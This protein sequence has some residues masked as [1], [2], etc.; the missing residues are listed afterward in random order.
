MAAPSGTVTFLFTDIEG[1]TRLYQEDEHVMAAAVARHNEVLEAIIAEH[2]GTVFS[3]M[4]D[5][6]AA[7]FGSA[8]AAVGAAVDLQRRLDVER[9]PTSR[10]I[11]V[12]VGLHTGEARLLGGDYFGAAVNRAARLMAIGHGGQVLCSEATA[13]VLTGVELVDLGEH[14]LRDLDRAVHVFQ[15]GDG[16]FP[17]LR[18]LEAHPSNL[19]AEV[20]GFVGRQDE[21][22]EVEA[23]LTAARVVTL[24]GAGGVGKTR[25]ALRAAAEALAGFRDGVRLVELSPLAD[26]TRLVE[27]VAGGLGVTERAGQALA[28]AVTEYLRSRHLLL[29]LDNCEHLG[30]ATGRW[31]A[32][33]VGSCP[34][35]WVLATSRR[36]LGVRGERVV[37]VAPLAVPAMGATP[38]EIGATD[39]ARLF[40]DRAADAKSSFTLTKANAGAVAELVRLLDGIP[41][42]IELAAARIRSFTPAELI[43]LFAQTGTSGGFEP[44]RR[45]MDWSY[46]LLDGQAM[47]ALNR[48]SVF[49]GDFDLAAARAVLGAGPIE[50]REVA[51]LLNSLV[52][53]SL[54]AAE[55]DGDATRYRLL[56]T[57][58]QYATEHLDAAGEGDGSRRRHAEH[59]A[60]FAAQARDGSRTSAERQWLAR[61]AR[62]AANLRSAVTWATS[63]GDT[64]L[65]LRLVTPLVGLTGSPLLWA[66][67]EWVPAVIAMPGAAAHPLYPL[68]LASASWARLVTGDTS[69]ALEMCHEALSAA[70]ETDP[71]PEVMAD[72]L[73]VVAQSFQLAGD[74]DRALEVCQRS[75]EL[76][77]AAGDD[78]HL[79]L[80]LTRA[81]GAAPWIDAEMASDLAKE[82]LT[83]GR[84]LGGSMHCYAALS[85]GIVEVERD[86][87]RALAL[88]GESAA[89]AEEAGDDYAY[90]LPLGFQAWLLVHRGDFGQ[91]AALIARCLEAESRGRS[92]FGVHLLLGVAAIVLELAGDDE[93]SAIAHGPAANMGLPPTKGFDLGQLERSAVTVRGRLSDQHFDRW[94][95]RGLAMNDHDLVQYLVDHLRAVEPTVQDG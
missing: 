26:P 9:W 54:I 38:E 19:P 68:A 80:A 65:A 35:L 82:A 17:A 41:L 40:V 23:S 91:A 10:P 83:V 20:G 50:P 56:E 92:S 14:R 21:L 36:R 77:R 93:A 4:G 75:I 29:V 70:A 55:D 63:V 18:S 45:A 85:A 74:A 89:V 84:R 15:V 32:N 33:A 24:T 46:A 11:R 44:L 73:S 72:V 8:S 13:S 42:A 60:T 66:S 5:G 76:A 81:C 43:E 69:T 52:D 27:V 34:G 49:A 37:M 47:T 30:D 94:A 86:P 79:S 7:A 95:A 87:D 62:E 31:V 71:G 6:K 53:E 61:A 78:W 1:S 12:R 51:E 22:A 16:V 57:I 28:D 59:Y 25:L 88:F 39:G 67:G 90:G 3:T 64:D 48:A 58:R 2:S